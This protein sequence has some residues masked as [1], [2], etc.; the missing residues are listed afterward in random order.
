MTGLKAKIENE[1][2]TLVQIGSEMATTFSEKGEVIS[3]AKYQTWFTRALAAVRELLPDR[4]TEFVALYEG[5]HRRKRDKE[6]TPLSYGIADYL[7]G[8]RVL[9]GLEEDFDHKVAIGFK[10]VQ[11]IGILKSAKTRLNDI[12]ANIRG[13]LQAELFDTELDAA[14]ELL[15][16]GH[17]RAAGA[18]A[19][20]VLERHLSTVASS[21]N[22]VVRK[23][24]PSISDWNDALK[25]AGV[26]DIP[27]WRNVQR[28]GDLRNVCC[29]DKKREPI[30]DEVRE[31]IEGTDK[32]AKTLA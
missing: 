7:S 14:R 27:V 26:I 3:L 5:D 8:V 19:G 15:E 2:N 32:L 4:L 9:R 30:V 25:S 21:R 18:V 31:L 22:V 13:T 6:I 17:L 11:Q 12:L 28:L 29:H 10:L 16:T 24:D 20:V 1:L 23:K